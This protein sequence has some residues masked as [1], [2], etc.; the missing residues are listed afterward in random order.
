M[1]VAENDV[2]QDAQQPRA[3]RGL[4]TCPD[5]RC[6]GQICVSTGM[7]NGHL[8]SIFKCERCGNPVENHP[9]A[10]ELKAK[11]QLPRREPKIEDFVAQDRDRMARLE[12]KIKDYDKASELQKAN[13]KQLFERVL[14]LE[15]ATKK[16]A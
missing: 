2:E 7:R 12:T 4:G 8:S 14:V 1:L 9:M 16:P 5:I 3:E 13:I 10:D 11:P 6:G 15:K